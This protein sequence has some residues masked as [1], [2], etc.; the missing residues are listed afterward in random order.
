MLRKIAAGLVCIAWALWFGGLGSLFLFVTDLFAED[1]ETALKAAPRLFLVF[2]RYQLLLAA[3]ALLGA[4]AWR[5]LAKSV[6]VTALFWMLAIATVPAALGPVLITSRMER[7][8]LAGE[9]SS[10]QFKKLHGESMIVYCG[11]T[12]VLLAVGLTLPWAMREKEKSNGTTNP[13]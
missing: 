2:E 6:R 3:A 8:R 12:I 5:V 7:L 9:S 10:P 1:R 4:V 13:G 11:E